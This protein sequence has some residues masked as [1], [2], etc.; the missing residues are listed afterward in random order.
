MASNPSVPISSTGESFEPSDHLWAPQSEPW[1]SLRKWLGKAWL[2]NRNGEQRVIRE[3][4][5]L[6]LRVSSNIELIADEKIFTFDKACT[7]RSDY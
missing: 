3:Q 7:R 1:T 6:L 2:K 4:K 5:L